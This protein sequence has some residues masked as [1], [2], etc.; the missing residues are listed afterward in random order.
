MGGVMESVISRISSPCN[1]YEPNGRRTGNHQCALTGGRYKNI[2]KEVK[3]Y[4]RGEYG[5]APGEVNQD[6]V[7]KV[8]GNEQPM[9]IRFAD[10]LE[11]AFDKVKGKLGNLARNDEDVLSYIAFPQIAEKFFSE[12][13][14]RESRS[15]TYTIIRKEEEPAV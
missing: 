12:R 3:A 13:E 5:N 1:A 8:L 9:T 15:V 10:T 4:L 11:P 2:T 14:E 6:L 7:Q